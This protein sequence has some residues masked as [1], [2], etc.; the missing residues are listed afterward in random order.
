MIMIEDCGDTVKLHWI[1][2]DNGEKGYTAISRQTVAERFPELLRGPTPGPIEQIM[3][4]NKGNQKTKD[5]GRDQQDR[6]TGSD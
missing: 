4:F 1:A 5:Y 3:D 6:T 2:E